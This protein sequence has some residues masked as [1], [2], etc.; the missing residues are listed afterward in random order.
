MD[1]MAMCREVI[2]GNVDFLID[3]TNPLEKDLKNKIEE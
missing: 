1:A 3:K 2:N